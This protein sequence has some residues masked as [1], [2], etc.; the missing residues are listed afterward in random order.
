LKS[1]AAARSG[2]FIT[3]AKCRRAI[4]AAEMN[5]DG[6]VAEGELVAA[7]SAVRVR[8]NRANT[9]GRLASTLAGGGNISF[10]T[11]QFTRNLAPP[12]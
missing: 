9:I 6:L 5:A 2:M 10:P 8:G 4:E 1:A 3:D 11:T 7:R 12:A